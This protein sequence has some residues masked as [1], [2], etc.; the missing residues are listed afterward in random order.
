MIVRIARAKV[1]HCQ[2]PIKTERPGQKTGAFCLSSA[3]SRRHGSNRMG[4]WIQL[5]AADGA[6]ISAWR[7]DPAGK[8][9]GGLV[10]A[11]EIFGVNSH[12]RSVCD[13]YAAD[14]C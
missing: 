2:A 3:T 11:Q 5:T 1:G 6:T 13:G 7:A 8:P 10:V 4:H 12:I 14:G 9:R